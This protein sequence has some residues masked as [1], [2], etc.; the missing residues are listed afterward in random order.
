MAFIEPRLIHLLNDAT[1]PQLGHIDLPPFTEA[2]PE[3]SSRLTPL[4]PT[5]GRRDELLG[6]APPTGNHGSLSQ[7]TGAY[8]DVGATL[9][10]PRRDGD[11]TTDRGAIANV[12]RIPLRLLLGETDEASHMYA[13][14]QEADDGP[15]GKDDPAS[16]K[17]HRAM[18][19]KDDL[20]HLPQPVKKQKAASQTRLPPMPPIINGLHEPPPNAALFPPISSTEFD[21]PD[22]D[23]AQRQPAARELPQVHEDKPME[24]E[25]SKSQKPG[26]V[27]TRKKAMKPRRKWSESE[28]THLLLG[29]NR[30][31]VGKWTDI[32]AD[33]EFNFNS[34]TAGDLKD[35]FRTCC[36]T[37]LR[38]NGKEKSA[39]S[40]DPLPTPPAEAK[41]KAKT[42]L[43]SE[44]ILIDP[45]EAFDPDQC[46][47]NTNDAEAVVK[48]K[49]SRAHRKK[50]EDLAELGIHGPFKK[51]H[52]RE[53]RPFSEQDDLQILEG[54]DKY[55]PSWTKIQRDPRFSLS[56]RQPTDL[57]DRVRNKY[58]DVYQRIERGLLHL[59]ELKERN[60]SVDTSTNTAKES[61]SSQPRQAHQGSIAQLAW[62]ED[63]T[64][65]T[66]SPME[67]EE[68]PVV[69]QPFELTEASTTA[70]MGS[71][72][73]GLKKHQK[74]LSAPSHWLL[75]KLSGTYAPRP[76]AGPHKLRDCMPLIVFLRNRLKYA[77]NF[78]ET[79]SIMMQRLVKVDGKVR[80]DITYPA[81]F[82]DVITIEK[83]GENFRLIYDIKGRFTVHRIQAEEAEY[84][85]GKVK[86]VQLGRGGVPF[87]VTHDARTI[88]YPD[89]LIKV[90]DTV[91]IDLATGKITD[92]IKFD[93]GAIAMVTGG[94]NMG[95]VGVITHRERHDGGF[96]IIH[97]KDAIDNTFATRES[98]VFVIGS[99]K[100][101]ISLPKGKGVKLTIAEERD[102]RRAHAIAGQ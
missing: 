93:T 58:P 15:E 75:D 31:G 28:T 76:S 24:V 38:K 19:N 36:P 57:R 46:Q 88:R 40:V 100:P 17:R 44:N 26:N 1:T 91:K 77:L 66:V 8:D 83:T 11:A 47:Q 64:R 63:L 59:K 42:G 43:L 72:G 101:W 55:G 102:R 29:V 90:N 37:E 87:L 98:N 74:R 7:T 16:K 51:S 22:P 78:R 73:K 18:T 52:R 56:G 70:F 30:H 21:T 89:P 27:K 6:A 3:A 53:R 82:M 13:P 12:P 81:G 9:R 69:P 20:M 97:V 49:K 67:S 39:A 71:M 65:W 54:L 61:S 96:N 23:A 25:P 33:P 85:L 84:K 50:I 35:R 45:D 41:G 62:K 95:R 99:E 32:L 92:F 68:L 4:G 94:R 86:R 60:D 5:A 14:G 48:H 80:T 2:F 34:R 79:R 10:D